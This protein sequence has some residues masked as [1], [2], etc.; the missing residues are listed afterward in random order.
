MLQSG[1]QAKRVRQQKGDGGD[2][3]EPIDLRD[4]GTKASLG[5]DYRH[6]GDAWFQ[7]LGKRGNAAIRQ[8]PSYWRD[9]LRWKYLSW[10]H[11]SLGKLHGLAK[12]VH[13]LVAEGFS[14]KGLRRSAKRRVKANSGQSWLAERA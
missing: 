13:H 8:G 3:R 14:L 7:R 11:V 5:G 1:K 12:R 2:D 10:R 9:I 6:N 4:G